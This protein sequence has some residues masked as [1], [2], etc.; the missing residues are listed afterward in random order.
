MRHAGP[1]L[2]ASV[3]A[4]ACGGEDDPCAAASGEPSIELGRA[5]TA[6]YFCRITPEKGY[7][8][9]AGP[10]GA[11]MFEHVALRVCGLAH[12]PYG[13]SPESAS[14]E[15]WLDGEQFG[16]EEYF[17]KRV[18]AGPEGSYEV[19]GMRIVVWPEQGDTGKKLAERMW[20]RQVRLDA[21][22][23]GLSGSWEL[24]ALRPPTDECWE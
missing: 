20:G 5:S 7:V 19:A 15:V 9:E 4:A 21:R 2:L 18:R 6:Q 23:Q 1:L 8:F 3:L 24:T 10:Q 16:D 22:V 14:L 17:N 12:P 11:A 13:R